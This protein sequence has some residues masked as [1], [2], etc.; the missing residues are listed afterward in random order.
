MQR[1]YILFNFHELLDL[2]REEHFNMT[3]YCRLEKNIV[4]YEKLKLESLRRSNLCFWTL[5]EILFDVQRIL[6]HNVIK[7]PFSGHVHYNQG[8]QAFDN[9]ALVLTER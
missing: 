5:V 6:E 1:I 9:M 7:T 3:L 4:S 2:E 8:S